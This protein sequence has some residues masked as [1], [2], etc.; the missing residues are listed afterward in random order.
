M[1]VL[2]LNLNKMKKKFVAFKIPEGR[3]DIK[4]W[5]KNLIKDSNLLMKVIMQIHYL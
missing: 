4:I 5:L 1:F 3:G 2:N